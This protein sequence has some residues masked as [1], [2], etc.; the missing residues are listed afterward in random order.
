ML[1]NL[2][3][4]LVSGTI[5]SGAP[6]RVHSA[7]AAGST[8]VALSALV[9]ERATDP[10][11][12]RGDARDTDENKIR[13]ISIVGSQRLEPDT[14][15]SYL[16]LRVGW[17][18]NHDAL[19]EATRDLLATEL[20]ADVQIRDDDGVLT[21]SVIENPIINRIILEG[22]RQLKDDK[23]WNELKLA[24]RQIF[25]RSKVR[26]DVSR[27]VELYRRQGRFATTVEPMMVKLDQN[28]VDIIF[29]IGE[30][31]KS[32]VRQI[33]IIGNQAFKDAK[34]KAQ[35]SIKECAT[36]KSSTMNAEIIAD[37]MAYDQIRLRQF[38]VD[39][40]YPDFRFVSAVAE[41]EPNK[42]NFV[43][44]YVV[45]EAAAYHL[46]PLM[47]EDKFR[48]VRSQAPIKSLGFFQD[49]FEIVQR[50]SGEPDRIVLEATIP[51]KPTDGFQ[52][53]R[54]PSSLERFILNA[55]IQ[56]RE[57]GQEFRALVNV[58][59]DL[60]IHEGA[61]ESLDSSRNGADCEESVFRKHI[62]DSS[63]IAAKVGI[64]AFL[65][66]ESI[67]I[68]ASAD[69]SEL[70]N[71]S[72]IR[73]SF[74][75][76]DIDKLINI[77]YYLSFEQSILES[78]YRNG[79]IN[80][81]QSIISAERCLKFEDNSSRKRVLAASLESSLKAVFDEV[82]YPD[83]LRANYVD[84]IIGEIL[85]YDMTG[86]EPWAARVVKDISDKRLSSQSPQLL[87]DKAPALWKTDKESGDTPPD[88]I[89]RHYG[90]WLKADATGLTRPDIKRL[91]PSLYMALANWLR[92]NELPDDCPVPIKSERV[93]ADLRRFLEGG[94]GAIVTG[95]SDPEHVLR[96]AR[97]I[98]S[99]S[100]RRR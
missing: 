36:A 6:N 64:E 86:R 65:D 57:K 22:N 30:G 42:S 47:P 2:E 62:P 32:R 82:G 29:E 12:S 1:K 31:P 40:G 46:E 66:R 92:K 90:L 78:V 23:I 93:N 73:G 85:S 98:A 50:S 72:Y 15:R 9:T 49:K 94:I 76:I 56:F 17:T 71:I 81:I 35:M 8:F 41:Q 13:A 39:N 77:D 4:R 14:V 45:D 68:Q 69:K 21:I 11:G 52:Q 3:S 55:A 53:S 54:G 88:F 38:Y 61:L 20:F 19:D 97:R 79:L 95:P 80:E 5:L 63:I 24:P 99:A 10:L 91:D 83:A 87:P 18:Y 33:N 70:A 43:I 37:A 84:R 60:S 34:L 27:I 26:A 74:P 96:E 100:Q 44:T 59:K 16:K 25:T 7:S 51:E 58:S 75:D 48:V 28:R 67:G 89:M